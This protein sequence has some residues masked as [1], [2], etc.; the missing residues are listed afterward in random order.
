MDER[1]K[2][3][4]LLRTASLDQD[5]LRELRTSPSLKDYEQ[6]LAGSSAGD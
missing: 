2:R 1:L 6:S 4:E 5:L 3:I